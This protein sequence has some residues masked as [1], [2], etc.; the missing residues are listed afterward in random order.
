M[1]ATERAFMGGEGS[2]SE[3]ERF[4]GAIASDQHAGEIAADVISIRVLGPDELLEDRQRP[5]IERPPRRKLTLLVQQGREIVEA[6]RGIEVVFAQ[7][8]RA[9]GQRSLEQRPGRG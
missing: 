3:R 9:N 4:G 6:V 5:L 7:D 1:I 2:F 8:L